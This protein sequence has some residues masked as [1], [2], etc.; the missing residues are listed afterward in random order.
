MAE[1]F[2]GEIIHMGEDGDWV[3]NEPAPALGTWWA[4]QSIGDSV[5]RN[6]IDFRGP[7]GPVFVAGTRVKLG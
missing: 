5:E 6:T 4:T 2:V 3:L 7:V 1:H